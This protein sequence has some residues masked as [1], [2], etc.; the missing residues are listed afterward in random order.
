MLRSFS[1][2]DQSPRRPH[3]PNVGS[4]A[5]ALHT[6]ATTAGPWETF[7]ITWI[8]PTHFGIKTV[9][10]NYV[11]AVNDGGIGG[12]NDNTSPVHTDATAAGPWERL[13]LNYD[14]SSAR[15]TFQTL[16]GQFLTAVNGGGFGGPNNVPIHTDATVLGPWETFTLELLR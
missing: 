9:N 2:R 6:D 11:T 1:F 7:E 4:H 3:G 15:A 5:V 12:P 13:L 14:F 16:N 10:G 8:D